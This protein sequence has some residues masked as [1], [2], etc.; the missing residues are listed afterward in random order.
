M[1]PAYRLGF[2][3]YRVIDQAGWR[4]YRR[5]FCN[6]DE[7]RRRLLAAKLVD[8]AR[9]EVAHHGVDLDRFRPTG[10][11][12]RY[13]L[14]PGRIM[15]QKNIE[16]ALA[17]WQEFKPSPELNDFQLVIAG[18][19]DAKS[20]AYLERL[21]ADSSSR[22]DIVFEPSPPDI[23]MLHLYQSAQ[24]VVVPAPNEDWGLVVLEAM[25]CGKPV[26]AVNRGGPRESIIDGQTGFLRMDTRAEFA[27]A[28]RELTSMPEA[29]MDRMSAAARARAEQFSWD[30]FVERI[31]AH[32]EELA[33]NS[34]ADLPFLRPV[35]EGVAIAQ[36][37]P[38]LN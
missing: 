2:W 22:P 25:A 12:S 7:V 1:K 33:I 32:V 13:L 24:G 16:L 10:E 20:R 27:A 26:L 31:D 35:V 23:R 38:E 9:I 30:R 37:G 34:T 15:W 36:S 14:V 17:A 3:T 11:R 8:D 19:V 5:V 18:M 6:S 4:R 29:Q 21:R 28:M